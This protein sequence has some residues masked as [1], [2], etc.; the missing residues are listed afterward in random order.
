MLEGQ[1][2]GP[3]GAFVEPYVLAHEYGHHIQ[4]LLGTMGQ[5]KTQQGPTSDSVRLELQ[6]DCYAGMWAKNATTT[7]DATGQPLIS[8]LTDDDIQQAHRRGQGRRRRPDPAA[9]RRAGQPRAVDPRLGRAAG[10]VVQHRLRAG[11]ASRPAT[12]SRTNNL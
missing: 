6:A 5:V 2:G 9:D 3:G 11:H 4:N 7:D 8:D 12:R 1:L 10:A